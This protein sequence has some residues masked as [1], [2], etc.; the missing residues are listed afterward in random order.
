MAKFFCLL[1]LAAMPC[2]LQLEEMGNSTCVRNYT[3]K[4]SEYALKMNQ[5]KTT[6]APFIFWRKTAYRLC[7]KT[8]TTYK[9]ENISVCCQGYVNISGSCIKAPCNVNKYG[10]NCSLTCP[11]VPDQY[12]SCGDNGA[13]LC[14]AGWTGE[15]CSQA[16]EQENYGKG[17]K[18]RCTCQNNATC[19]HVTGICNC[20]RVVGKTGDS[21][22][23]DCPPRFYGFNCSSSCNCSEFENPVCS[24]LSG[25]CT[26]ESGKTGHNCSDD[27]RNNTFGPDCVHSC[28]CVTENSLSCNSS[29]GVCDCKAGWIGRRCEKRCDPFHFGKGCEEN[30]SCQ[31]TE[32]CNNENGTCFSASVCL[33]KNT[34][35]CLPSFSLTCQQVSENCNQTDVQKPSLKNDMLD[36][37]CRD[38]P[39]NLMD[40]I[41]I[42]QDDCVCKQDYG[43]FACNETFAEIFAMTSSPDGMSG[44][45]IA[46]IVV[47]VLILI[48]VVFAVAVFRCRKPS[49]TRKG[50]SN[51]G[52][53]TQNLEDSLPIAKSSLE[54]QDYDTTRKDRRQ[55]Q[56]QSE[57]YD[58]NTHDDNNYGY[59]VS[60]HSKNKVKEDHVENYATTAFTEEYDHLQRNDV[61][62]V[63]DA[64]YSYSHPPVFS[65]SSE[66]STAGM[67]VIQTDADYDLTDTPGT[68]DDNMYSNTTNI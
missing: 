35:N 31:S 62:K 12:E 17:C 6:T 26:C 44:S 27:C 3:S 5:C 38:P 18:H 42:S 61:S 47:A 68:Q 11:C 60:T 32:V 9:I 53:G 43:G 2:F 56:A 21:C 16:C 24:P 10:E 28:E 40:S 22:D 55:D 64:D 51:P 65:D 48:G 23:E 33:A 66:Y 37:C 39:V 63:E 34:L 1:L 25:I 36:I 14:S 29:S 50:A 7:P 45:S 41:C 54:N 46:G 4:K 13:C 52:Y 30:C 67:R 49:T 8:V 15:N 20:S 58:L 59:D 57:M 19:D